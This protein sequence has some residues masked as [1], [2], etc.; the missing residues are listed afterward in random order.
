MLLNLAISFEKNFSILIQYS[1]IFFEAYNKIQQTNH[2]ISVCGQSLRESAPPKQVLHEGR[3]YTELTLAKSFS[4]LT[5]LAKLVTALAFTIITAFLGLISVD[6]RALWSQG[7]SGKEEMIIYTDA[8]VDYRAKM[9]A[10]RF[11][12]GYIGTEDEK[13][14]WPKILEKPP[15]RNGRAAASSARRLCGKGSSSPYSKRSLGKAT[16]KVVSSFRPFE[17]NAYR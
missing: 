6:V 16:Q 15:A 13:T 12:V 5:T 14:V 1:E 11:P 9:H 7:L 4:F 3:R 2:T 10:L 17:D 8:V